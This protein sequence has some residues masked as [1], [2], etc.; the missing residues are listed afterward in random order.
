MHN[1]VAS[2][3]GGTKVTIN[4]DFTIIFCNFLILK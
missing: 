4:I 3:I 1:G 2:L